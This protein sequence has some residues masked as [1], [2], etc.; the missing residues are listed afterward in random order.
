MGCISCQKKKALL[1][2][3]L[4]RDE[5]CKY[6][7]IILPEDGFSFLATIPEDLKHSVYCG[8]CYDKN[9]AEQW[10]QYQKT[11]EQAKNINVYLSNQGKETRLIKRTEDLFQVR[12]CKDHD[13]TLLRLAFYAVRAGFNALVDVDVTSVK[14]RENNYQTLSWSGVARPANIHEKNVIKDRTFWKNPN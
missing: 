12:D 1:T 9:V 5:V 11:L 13:E 8:T 10:D 7:A 3:G 2:C 4:C 6:C 14:V